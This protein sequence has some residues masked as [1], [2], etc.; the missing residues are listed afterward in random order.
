MKQLPRSEKEIIVVNDGSSDSTKEA[1]RCVRKSAGHYGVPS[2][3]NL[4]KG[5]SVR[6]G[7]SYANGDI[8]TI[9]DADLELD[10]IEYLKLIQPIID[11]IKMCGLWI[12]FK[13]LGL[14][15]K[16]GNIAFFIANRALLQG[17]R[18]FCSST[19]SPISKPATKFFAATCYPSSR[20][21]PRASGAEPEL[22][23][24][25]PQKRA[26]A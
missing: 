18:A 15:Q 3:V 14:L 1:S 6:L 4:G 21:K 24:A 7:F 16:K 10:P 17:W 5:A 23:G 2:R 19:S 12:A 22:D 13:G 25:D 8:I 9:Q 11:A 26:F 20:S